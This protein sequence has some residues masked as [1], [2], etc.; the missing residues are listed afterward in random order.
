[1]DGQRIELPHLKFADS[2]VIEAVEEIDASQKRKL[3]INFS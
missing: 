2:Y 1:M 3:S